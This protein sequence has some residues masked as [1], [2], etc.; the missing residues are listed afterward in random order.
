MSTPTSPQALQ[1]LCHNVSLW[2]HEYAVVPTKTGQN[3][4]K[5]EGIDLGETSFEGNTELVIQEGH[6]NV[7]GA[8]A[9]PIDDAVLMG[10]RWSNDEGMVGRP[11]CDDEVRMG[12]GALAK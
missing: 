2:T 3:M 11:W 12:D 10:W 1:T 7:I 8:I 5:G 9:A 6:T 4:L